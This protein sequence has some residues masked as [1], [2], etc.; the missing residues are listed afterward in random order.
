MEVK[1]QAIRYIVWGWGEVC[2]LEVCVR[3]ALPWESR[4]KNGREGRRKITWRLGMWK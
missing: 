4:R 2:E 3:E 1:N